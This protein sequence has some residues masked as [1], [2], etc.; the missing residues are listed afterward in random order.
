MTEGEQ[1]LGESKGMNTATK[2]NRG[3]RVVGEWLELVKQWLV[4]E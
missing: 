2:A 3:G 4:G 1:M